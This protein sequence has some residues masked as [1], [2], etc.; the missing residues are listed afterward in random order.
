[1]GVGG[2]LVETSRRVDTLGWCNLVKVAVRELG[3]GKHAGG[4]PG[5]VAVGRTDP[6]HPR[7]LARAPLTKPF[8]PASQII[9]SVGCADLSQPARAT[10][11]AR[12]LQPRSGSRSKPG[13]PG[14][15]GLWADDE[16]GRPAS[17]VRRALYWAEY[18][19][20][21][22]SCAMICG[23]CFRNAPRWTYIWL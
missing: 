15:S 14:S 8:T 23:S 16:G 21:F 18:L 10:L 20:V 11:P 2:A 1:M 3:T 5:W 9:R 19:W 4:S 22:M 7:S 6:A 13:E 12:W 17:L